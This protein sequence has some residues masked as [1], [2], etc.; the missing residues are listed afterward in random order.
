MYFAT[1]QDAAQQPII[2]FIV[3]AVV[4]HTIYYS[5]DGYDHKK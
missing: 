4:I 3:T 2:F 1:C 5:S